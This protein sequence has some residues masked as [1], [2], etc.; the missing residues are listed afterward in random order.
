[1]ILRNRNLLILLVIL[2][3]FFL[4]GGVYAK[5][6]VVKPKKKVI[7]VKVETDS[8]KE[9]ISIDTTLSIE[10][11]FD[12]GELGNVLD[13]Q[14]DN[15]KEM[16]E[17]LHEMEFDIQEFDW[18]CKDG[19][20]MIICGQL[21]KGYMHTGCSGKHMG[22]GKGMCKVECTHGAMN[23]MKCR[24]G[25]SLSD[26]LGNIPMSAVKSY[27]IKETKDGKKIVIEV[28]DEWSFS[29]DMD[30]MIL[31]RPPHMPEPPD[32]DLMSPDVEKKV[33]IREVPEKE[34]EKK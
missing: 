17:K 20:K 24:K 28:S 8:G 9:T 29:N 10:G 18:N 1:M 26:V 16:Q 13:L 6:T 30:I 32:V 11:D 12:I 14:E 15:L 31:G 5:D 22:M 7:R 3:V 21:P 23:V 34:P 19:K 27:K 2:G 4:S 33:I 25:E